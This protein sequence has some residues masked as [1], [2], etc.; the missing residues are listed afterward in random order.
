[1]VLLS[2]CSAARVLRQS[3]AQVLYQLW[4]RQTGR[5]PWQYLVS[6][7]SRFHVI[8][9]TVFFCRYNHQKWDRILP[10][11]GITILNFQSRA[12]TRCRHT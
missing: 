7:R 5:A 12:W 6:F 8:M 1:M 10:F 11:F 2:D 3:V 4:K 9:N